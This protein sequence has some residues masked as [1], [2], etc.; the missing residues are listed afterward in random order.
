MD[1]IV[2][3]GSSNY[4]LLQLRGCLIVVSVNMAIVGGISVHLDGGYS[5]IV[6]FFL[7]LY[8]CFGFLVRGG[9]GAS[10]VTSLGRSLS[11]TSRALAMKGAY[12]ICF[13]RRSKCGCHRR[14][15]ER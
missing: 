1:V 4:I 15:P 11:I 5:K 7:V 6:G 13:P 14:W 9:I 3:L 2:V 12:M 10:G 8:L